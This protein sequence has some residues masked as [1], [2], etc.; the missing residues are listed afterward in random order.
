MFAASDNFRAY[1]LPPLGVMHAPPRQE[2]CVK[3]V[4]RAAFDSLLAFA[5]DEPQDQ[6]Q[7]RCMDDDAWL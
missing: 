5:V 1:A 3:R 4:A 7:E 6:H 2:L